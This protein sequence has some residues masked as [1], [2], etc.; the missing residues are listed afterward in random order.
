MQ[1]MLLLEG[2]IGMH[3]QGSWV[4]SWFHHARSDQMGIA[5][6]HYP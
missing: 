4:V 3:L 5:A 2:S 1:D 6:Q